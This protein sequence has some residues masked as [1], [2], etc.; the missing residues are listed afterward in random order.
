MKRRYLAVLLAAVVASATMPA[1]ADDAAPLHAGQVT[2]R[3]R[4]INQVADT[5]TLDTGDTFYLG[6]AADVTAFQVG[7]HVSITYRGVGA[8]KRAITVTHLN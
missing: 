8:G 5:V 2:G 6:K 1:Q 3:I 4:S 7:D